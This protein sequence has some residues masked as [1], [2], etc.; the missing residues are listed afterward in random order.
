MGQGH[1]DKSKKKNQDPFSRKKI[2]KDPDFNSLQ[3][4]KDA[5]TRQQQNRKKEMHVQPTESRYAE[6]VDGVN[7]PEVPIIEQT[8]AREAYR[9]QYFSQFKK[10]VDGADV[11]LEVLDARDPIGCRSK[12]LEDYILKRGKRIVLV[13]NKADL[14][15]IEVLNK[16]LMFLRREFPV[17]PF[18][19]SSQPNKATYVPLH[20]GKWRS[21]DVFGVDG[22]LKLLNRFAGGSSIVAGVIGAPNVGKSSV[23]NSLSR[24]NAAGVASTPGFTKTMQEVEVT[25]RIRILDCPGVV[26]SSGSEI[27]PSMILRNS[28]KIELLEDPVAPVSFILEKVPKD[29]LIS[30][31]GIETFGDAHD[32]LSQLAVKRGKL[33]KGAEPDI[34]IT[35]RSI[36][37][38]WNKGRIKY[39]TIPPTVDDTVECSTELIDQDGIVY[40]MGKVISF[41]EDD[42]KNFQI[43]HVFQVVSRNNEVQKP[44]QEDDPEEEDGET[45][46][47][48][49]KSAIT[50]KQ[51]NEL[52]SLAK[53][54]QG[55]SFD[56]F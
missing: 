3:K 20:D 14:I 30:V 10:V 15:P 47:K 41:T 46:T 24:R 52:D 13:L 17:I 8:A 53:E 25:S 21:T 40:P 56:D 12:K 44:H 42:F 11:L 39:Y 43:E 38:D 6:I 26:P 34:D 55:I 32:F 1:K 31:Y 36:L 23:I 54:F 49:K 18:K 37:D 45:T 7:A 50:E 28:I 16:W 33:L 27:T 9:T 2:K 5:L 22:L 4:A 35:A 48:V 29:Q 51:K 19:S